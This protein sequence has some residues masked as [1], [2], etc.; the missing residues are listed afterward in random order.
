[1]NPH[2]TGN[3]FEAVERQNIPLSKEGDLHKQCKRLLG[4]ATRSSSLLVWYEFSPLGTSA[5]IWSVSKPQKIDDK[6]CGI[7][8]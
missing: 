1:M 8:Y 2:C 3:N 5:T 4:K 6:E 7:V